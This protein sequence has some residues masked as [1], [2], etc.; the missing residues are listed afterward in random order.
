[1]AKVVTRAIILNNEKK[2][3]LGKRARNDAIGKWALVGG[4][5]DG[6]E[7]LEETIIREVKEE[8]GSEFAPIFW[9]EELDDSFGKGEE[10]RVI[11]FYGTAKGDYNINKDEVMEIDFFGPEELDTIDIAYDHKHILTRF[12]EELTEKASE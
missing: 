5:P 6:N 7:T 3:L 1:M 4:K 10:W 2:V 9:M 12:F 11:Y 8:L